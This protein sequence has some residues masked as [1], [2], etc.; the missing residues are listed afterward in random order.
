[1]ALSW[2][3]SNGS[4]ESRLTFSNAGGGNNI[5]FGI[6]Y[7]DNSVYRETFRIFANETQVSGS[8]VVGYSPQNN[9]G[10]RQLSVLGSNSNAAQP[11]ATINLTQVWNAVEYPVSLEAQ[12]GS[13]YGNASSDFVLKTSY[14]SSGINT[15][16]RMRITD[17]GIAQI[18]GSLKVQGDLTT[19][20]GITGTSIT[21]TRFTTSESTIAIPNS[22]TTIFDPG[23][24]ASGVW[25]VTA[26]V[27]ANNV[28]AGYAIVGMRGE[29]TLHLL[30][31]GVGGQMTFSVSGTTLRLSQS[32][33]G[34]INTSI[35]VMKMN[36]GG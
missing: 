30:S 15:V 20:G 5:R 12:Q 1:M 14:F 24:G 35:S 18:T 21:G 10:A 7:N 4:G 26:V 2:N 11:V 13:L 36:Q 33:G 22:A 29:S 17:S 34:T 16:Q 6:W 3:N 28:Q 19:T 9:G 32:A 27:Q 8:L 23:S 31:N 25:M